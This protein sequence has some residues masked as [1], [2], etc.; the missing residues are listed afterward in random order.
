MQK[1]AIHIKGTIHLCMLV[2]SFMMVLKRL[3][4]D[5]LFHFLVRLRGRGV[6]DRVECAFARFFIG[7]PSFL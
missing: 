2:K 5:H 3:T 1:G 7:F 4:F 6:R